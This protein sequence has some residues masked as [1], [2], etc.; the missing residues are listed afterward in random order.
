[1]KNFADIRFA[2]IKLSK[3]DTDD[4]PSR[5][6]DFKKKSNIWIFFVR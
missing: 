1:M 3:E 4:R 5:F 2:R 6:F